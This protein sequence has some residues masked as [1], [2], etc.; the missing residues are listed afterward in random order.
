MEDFCVGLILFAVSCDKLKRMSIFQ[1]QSP[2]SWSTPIG[3]I[4][5]V[6]FLSNLYRCFLFNLASLIYLSRKHF[7]LIMI[8]RGVFSKHI[9]N[10]FVLFSIDIFIIY[11]FKIYLFV[12]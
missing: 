11:S 8:A 1:G 2:A 7:F 4:M 3:S 5:W 12:I 6:L 10:K 9:K